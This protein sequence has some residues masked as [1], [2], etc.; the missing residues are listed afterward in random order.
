MAARQTE[1]FGDPA[2]GQHREMVGGEL[3]DAL[4]FAP[5]IVRLL[6]IARGDD[7]KPKSPS[8]SA[9][10]SARVPVTSASS[11]SSSVEWTVAMTA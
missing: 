3:E 1:I 4:V 10:S 5:I 2:D 7:A 6:E 11:S 8:R 9:I